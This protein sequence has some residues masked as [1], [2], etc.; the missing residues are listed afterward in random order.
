MISAT[1]FAG[2]NVAVFGLGASG[3]AAALSLVRGGATVTAWDDSAGAVQAAAARGIH[4]A[5]LRTADWQSFAALVLAPGV[6]LTHPQPHW[7]VVSARAAGIE[8]IGDIELFVRERR[9]HVPN[10]PLIAIT[11]TNGKST[12]AA[13]IAHMLKSAGRNVALGGNIGTSIMELEPPQSGRIHVI[14]CSSYQ[15]DLTPG[16][17]PTIGVLLNISADHLERHGTMAAYARIKERLVATAETAVIGVDDNWSQAVADRVANLGRPVIRISSRRPL[18]RGYCMRGDSIRSIDDGASVEAA[19]IGGIS[20]LRGTHNAQNAIA[21]VAT[22]RALG[23]DEDAVRAGLITFPGLAHRMEEVGREGAVLFVNDSKA[24]NAEAAARA[25]ASYNRIYW[26][27]GGQ[28]KEGGIASLTP[29]FPR[30]ARAYLIGEAA[31]DFSATLGDAVPHAIAGDLAAAVRA[32]AADAAMDSH[33]EPVVL[34]SPAGASFDQFDNFEDRGDQF[35][36]LV[37]EL[38]KQSE[39]EPA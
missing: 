22:L 35:R 16:L 33:D 25:L 7:S 15:I 19:R 12:T 17:A 21:A 13:L 3:C 26:I 29:F 10:A 32:A 5:D 8:I 28:Q 11:G 38:A 23:I 1:S 6:P 20:T 9:R 2:R 30:L 18:A 4:V 27:A 14:E 37:H 39:E 34:L 36:D 31:A 24:T